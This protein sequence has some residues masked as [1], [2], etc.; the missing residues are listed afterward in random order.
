MVMMPFVDIPECFCPAVLVLS[1]YIDILTAHSYTHVGT[2]T[3]S[4]NTC[5][6]LFCSTGSQ[7]RTC[8]HTNT[9]KHTQHILSA[10]WNWWSVSDRSGPHIQVL[11]YRSGVITYELL[12]FTLPCTFTHTRT[13][14]RRHTHANTHVLFTLPVM[15]DEGPVQGIDGSA[16]GVGELGI[17]GSGSET[18]QLS[19][20]GPTLVGGHYLATSFYLLFSTHSCSVL[21][22]IR[23][24]EPMHW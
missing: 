7:F 3:H 5:F 6:Q 23:Q 4:S 14:K 16:A 8:T 18:V 15:D 12:I 11:I 17:D 1:K 24:T 21:C 2:E 9:H 20:R 10:N 13:Q 19:R 22:S